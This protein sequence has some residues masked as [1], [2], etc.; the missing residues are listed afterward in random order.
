MTSRTIANGVT[1]STRLLYDS[2]FTLTNYGVI[3]VPSSYAVYVKNGSGRVTNAATASI[4]G[5][6]GGI[7]LYSPEF[8]T[9]PTVVNAGTIS[10]GLLGIRLIYESNAQS[11]GTVIAR[12][13]PGA[14]SN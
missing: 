3:D 8:S 13:Q 5:G 2:N 7:Y 1:V 14:R 4:Y 11:G 6:D 12:R 10:S 9:A